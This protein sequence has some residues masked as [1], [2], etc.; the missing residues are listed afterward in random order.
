MGLALIRLASIFGGVA[1]SVASQKSSV[2][3][4]L[5]ARMGRHVA[6]AGLHVGSLAVESTLNCNTLGNHRVDK[7]R[8]AGF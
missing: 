3:L 4:K 8:C 6:S 2:N 7:T 5:L 1:G